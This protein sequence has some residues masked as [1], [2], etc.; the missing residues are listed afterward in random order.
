MS[1]RRFN[2]ACVVLFWILVVLLLPTPASAGVHTSTFERHAA[3]D[4]A[5]SDAQTTCDPAGYRYDGFVNVG[6]PAID[7]DDFGLA[8]GSAA[9]ESRVLDAGLSVGGDSDSSPELVAPSGLA[10]SGPRP[11]VLSASPGSRSVAQINRHPGGVEYVFDPDSGVFALGSRAT[12]SY[13]GG[14]SP[15]EQ[16]A[17]AIGANSRTVVGGVARRGDDG[18]LYFDEMSGHYWQNWTN[19]ARASFLDA[20]DSYGIRHGGFG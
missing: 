4:T 20:L 9:R 8:P 1:R 2:V 13:R 18:L 3:S 12:S 5:V 7:V 17:D 6:A 16:L 19:D 10:G 15:H 11:G 14:L